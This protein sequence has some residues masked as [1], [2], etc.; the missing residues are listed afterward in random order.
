MQLAKCVLKRYKNKQYQNEITINN[1]DFTQK[2]LLKIQNTVLILL[3]VLSNIKNFKFCFKEPLCTLATLI[4][5]LVYV[6]HRFCR[7]FHK[8]YNMFKGHI[9]TRFV[10]LLYHI[11]ICKAIY[12]KG[13]VT[14]W[15]RAG[16]NIYPE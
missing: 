12:L 4:V 8:V 9:P 14:L 3:L 11:T 1:G 15:Y 16:V 10:S 7:R 2:K 13:F 6:S 5:E